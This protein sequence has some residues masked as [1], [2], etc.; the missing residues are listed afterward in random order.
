MDNKPTQLLLPGILFEE[1][2][3]FVTLLSGLR[4]SIESGADISNNIS[5]IETQLPLLLDKLK[6]NNNEQ[7]RTVTVKWAGPF[8]IDEVLNMRGNADYGVYQI[9][10]YH[11]IFGEDSLL[12]IG[13]TDRT[14]GRRFADHKKWLQEQEGVFIHVGRIVSD[15]DVYEREQ[16]IKDTEEL[17]IKRHIPPH[18]SNNIETY[19]GRLLKVINTGKYASLDRE[20]MSRE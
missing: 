12:Y 4:G 9:Y 1:I 15:Y 6:E 10:G 3:E 17:T 11:R 2:D 18:N 14:F 8:S 16:L 20:Y 19:N 7:L 13:K 5:R